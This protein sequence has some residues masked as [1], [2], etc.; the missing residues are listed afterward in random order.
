M[1]VTVPARSSVGSPCPVS[2]T[3]DAP[4]PYAATSANAGTPSRQ[5]RMFAGASTCRYHP[6]SGFSSHSITSRPGAANGSGRRM[7]AFTAEK[8][9][10]FAPMPNAR[11]NVA[12]SA[13]PGRRR[14]AR[15]A[16]RT[17]AAASCSARPPRTARWSSRTRST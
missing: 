14:S 1:P 6:F 9:A 2:V 15:S 10:A 5:S 11:M 4:S 13:S 12:A 3:D 8:I 17:S 16:S 7:T